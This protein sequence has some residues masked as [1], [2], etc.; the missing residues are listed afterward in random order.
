MEI[1]HHIKQI[2]NTL[3]KVPVSFLDGMQVPVFFFLD[4]KTLDDVLKTELV[5]YLATI[6]TL[7]GIKQAVIALPNLSRT[8]GVPSGVVI[9]SDAIDG[10]IFPA[11]VGYD[12]NCG[13]R[14]LRADCTEDEIK[15]STLK[16]ASQLFREIHSTIGHTP[17]IKI[18]TDKLDKVLQEGAHR[19]IK[20]GFGEEVDSHYVESFG[21]LEN[22]DP[23]AISQHAKKKGRE[24]LGTLGDGSHFIQIDKITEIFDEDAANA[25]NINK[26]QLI[27]LIH[28]DSRD[29]GHQVAIEEI[30]KVKEEMTRYY[31]GSV[32]FEL[33]GVPV[34]SLEGQRCFNAMAAAA[35]FAFANRQILTHELRKIWKD[36]LGKSCGSLHV[37]YDH[38]HNLAKLESHM[39]EGRKERLLVHRR[40]ATRAF[41][42]ESSELPADYQPVGQPLVLLGA[43]GTPSYLLRGSGLEQTFA[44]SSHGVGRVISFTRGRK[45]IQGSV[46]VE[47]L[48]T[49]GVTVSRNTC[50]HRRR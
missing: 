36:I 3:W 49:K 7:P 48:T 2:N 30:H 16:L 50:R 40:G 13:V 20:D 32:P 23:Q 8:D 4:E 46:T 1:T 15:S 11:A 47:S 6:A 12:I 29:L 44:S 27:I 28:S 17:S 37:L 10:F 26:G 39:I 22:A 43:M 34:S 19:L 42:P 9:A 14:I 25:Y 5:D 33:S 18:G 21:V 35:N 38:A 31:K 45:D 41:G 24:Q